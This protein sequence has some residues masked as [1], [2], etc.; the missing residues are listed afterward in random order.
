MSLVRAQQG[1]PKKSRSQKRSAFS[2]VYFVILGLSRHHDCATCCAERC[3]HIRS[4]IANSPLSVAKHCRWFLLRS[5]S[6]SRVVLLQLDTLVLQYSRFGLHH[7]RKQYLI[8]FAS[9]TQQ[10]EPYWCNNFAP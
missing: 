1:E 6:P 9:L 2:F 4:R 10:G 3:L 7:L 5:H 8:I